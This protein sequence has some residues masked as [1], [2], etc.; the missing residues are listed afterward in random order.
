ME[1]EGRTTI[2]GFA[3]KRDPVASSWARD[4][5]RRTR[6]AGPAEA[7]LDIS[8]WLAWGRAR[9][10]TRGGQWL[11]VPGGWRA[12]RGLGPIDLGCPRS[13]A[14]RGRHGYGAPGGL[15]DAPGR[16]SGRHGEHRVGVLLSAVVGRAAPRPRNRA[17]LRGHHGRGDRASRPGCLFRRRVAFWP[18]RSR[19]PPGVATAEHPT[20]LSSNLFPDRKR[21]S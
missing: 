21:T 20:V 4:D 13:G 2:R 9:I 7:V 10:P 6:E 19:D 14:P 12:P 11:L 3:G 1:D 15:P 16:R 5:L 17:R 8:R 18:A